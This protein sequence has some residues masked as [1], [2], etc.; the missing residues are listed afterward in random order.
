VRAGVFCGPV[1]DLSVASRLSLPVLCPLHRGGA[2]VSLEF[3][4]PYF[5]IFVLFV[6]SLRTL[7]M[8]YSRSDSRAMHMWQRLY[9]NTQS[10]DSRPDCQADA[11][12]RLLAQ[13]QILT[14]RFVWWCLKCVNFNFIKYI[15]LLNLLKTYGVQTLFSSCDEV[16]FDISGD[17]MTAM[18]ALS[19][20][21]FCGVAGYSAV[22]HLA[23]NY[24]IQGHSF[25]SYCIPIVPIVL[26]FVLQKVWTHVK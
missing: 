18:F 25:T 24:R 1:A 6:S 17:E 9:F 15:T 19:I 5:S 22:A 10:S 21:E 7:E 23:L 12:R 14:R 13:L 3:N 16:S 20:K 4:E 26:Y 11:W 2:I 8:D